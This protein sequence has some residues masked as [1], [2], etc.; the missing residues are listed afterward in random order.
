MESGKDVNGKVVPF[1]LLHAAM[2]VSLEL[3]LFPAD[4][5][6]LALSLVKALSFPP[7][8]PSDSENLSFSGV[9]ALLRPLKTFLKEEVDQTTDEKA[10][11][12]GKS[13]FSRL[14]TA[15]A[16]IVGDSYVRVRSVVH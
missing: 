7:V 9:S 15:T 13:P 11:F 1:R 12:R 6:A 5:E 3:P 16:K 14:L 8:T 2:K 10:L 4:A